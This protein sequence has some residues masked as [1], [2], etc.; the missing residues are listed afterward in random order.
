MSKKEKKGTQIQEFENV[1]NALSKSEAF[2]EKNQKMLLYGFAAIIL[3]VCAVLAYQNY[4]LTPKQ[5]DAQE[6]I[7]KAE[8]YFAKDSFQLALDGDGENLGFLAII[9][10]YGMTNV[11]DLAKAYA[12]ISYKALGD[13]EKAISYLKNFDAGDMALTPA[14]KGA[15]GDCYLELGEKEKAIAFFQKAAAANNDVVSPVYLQRTGLVYLSMG[16]YKK[17]LSAFE[18]IKNKYAS[19][20]QAMDIDKYIQLATLEQK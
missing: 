2:I 19:S 12:G 8:Q 11:A 18:E 7:F 13:Y 16:E 10:E 14:V 9:D 3:I 6:L 5:R 17:A 1:Q 20:Q 4:F 15:I